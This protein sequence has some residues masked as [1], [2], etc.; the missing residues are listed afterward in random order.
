MNICGIRI[1]AL[2]MAFALAGCA[3][4]QEGCQQKP[5]LA[6]VPNN[7]ELMDVRY[8]EKVSDELTRAGYVVVKDGAQCQIFPTIKFKEHGRVEHK[9]PASVFGLDVTLFWSVVEAGKAVYNKAMPDTTMTTTLLIT[10]GEKSKELP[11]SYS[12]PNHDYA[13]ICEEVGKDHAALVATA[14]DCF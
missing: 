5:T 14:L 11:R 8:Y 9:D 2:C 4:K 6:I 13:R 10:C 7:T 1:V 12:Y 3:A